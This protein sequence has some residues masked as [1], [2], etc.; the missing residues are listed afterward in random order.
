MSYLPKQGDIILLNFDPQKGREQKGR[1]PGLIVSNDQFYTHTKMALVC[2]ITNT[3]SG[4]PMHVALDERTRT[5]GEILC[6]QVK[7]LD[8]S[9]RDAVYEEFV[10]DDIMDEVIDLICSFID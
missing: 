8:I 9:V 2:P 7:C 5:S 3:I 4:F 10:Q 1:R 6:E